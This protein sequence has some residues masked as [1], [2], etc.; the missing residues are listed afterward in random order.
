[1]A[2]E[3]HGGGQIPCSVSSWA[4]PSN[5]TEPFSRNTARSASESAMLTDCSTMIIVM[6]SARS[7]SMTRSSSCT[8]SG[9]SPRLS[10]SMISTSGSCI[11]A[12][13]SA[14]ICC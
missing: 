1:M 13:A 11:S 7:P 9:A 5:R 6:P 12:I 8:T 14:I 10:S 2:S 4:V 3:E